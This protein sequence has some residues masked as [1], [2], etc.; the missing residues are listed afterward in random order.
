MNT[1]SLSLSR[2]EAAKLS[3]FLSILTY[4]DVATLLERHKGVSPDTSE[5]AYQIWDAVDDLSR[6]LQARGFE[7][8]VS[9][10]E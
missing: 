3:Q 7:G 8:L 4:D 6:V 2:D 1:I 9:E 10:D 5:E